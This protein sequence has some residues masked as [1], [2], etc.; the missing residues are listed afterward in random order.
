MIVNITER[1]LKRELKKI[2]EDLYL[3]AV[4]Q[5]RAFSKKNDGAEIIKRFLDENDAADVADALLGLACNSAFESVRK[6]NY[7]NAYFTAKKQLPLN[8]EDIKNILVLTEHGSNE[9]VPLYMATPEMLHGHS[10]R[11]TKNRKDVEVADDRLQEFIGRLLAAIEK[12]DCGTASD[13]LMLLSFE[14]K[15]QKNLF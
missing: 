1:L 4:N 9:Y 13:A 12:L 15:S 2:S 11:S 5:G 8:P 6:A 3:E 10:M 7:L 14:E